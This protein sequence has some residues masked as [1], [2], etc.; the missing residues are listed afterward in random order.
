MSPLPFR[1][2]RATAEV[3][4]ILYHA[5]APSGASPALIL[6]HGA[7]AGQHSPFMTRYAHELALRGTHV[8][9]FNFPYMEGKRR[10][11]DRAPVLEETFRGIIAAATARADL[12]G[13]RLF[14]GGKSMGGRIA[15][16]LAATPDAWS[17]PSPLQGVVVFGYPLHPPS[18]ARANRA[19]HLHH[20]A[21]PTLIVQG[22]RDSFGGP[23]EIRAATLE[24][25]HIDILEVPDGDHSFA[26]LK[27]S[28]RAQ[29]AVHREIWDRVGAWMGSGPIS[30]R[31]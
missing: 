5:V 30:R 3:S 18:G 6:A 31:P 4:A 9:T 29:D 20:L 16:H 12:A 21:A 24:A 11:P 19:A 8:V 17:G 1:V 28:G 7:G 10:A 2:P 25:R 14:I 13:A 26:V 27:R 23:D 22:T 15:T